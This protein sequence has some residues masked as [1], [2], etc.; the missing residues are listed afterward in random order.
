MNI[1]D[2]T[3][4]LIDMDKKWSSTIYEE[5]MEIGGGSSWAKW[6]AERTEAGL[7][8]VDIPV[9]KAKADSSD[10]PIPPHFNP[11]KTGAAAV[12]P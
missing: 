8:I 4:Q 6:K 9:P 2:G 11:L 3:K 1:G 5:L 12:L 10:K 7:P